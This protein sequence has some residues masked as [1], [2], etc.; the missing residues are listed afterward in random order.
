MIHMPPV[1]LKSV[2]PIL[3]VHDIS[4][5]LEFYQH[6]L[7]FDLAWSWGTPPELAAVCRDNVEITLAKRPDA[8][9][10]GPSRIYLGVSGIDAYYAQILKPGTKIVVP[11]GDRSY[12]MRDF[13]IA[14]PSGN[15]LNIGQTLADDSRR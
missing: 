10:S 11:I 12:G 14:D 8:Q 13:R 3:T 9:P 4:Q 5:A 2:S 7:G 15:E 1:Q 6:S